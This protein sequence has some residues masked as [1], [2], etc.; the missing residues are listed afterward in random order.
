[1]FQKLKLSAKISFI[2]GATLAL[3]LTI[4][5]SVSVSQ[6][7]SAIS[8]GADG[9]FEG[10]AT[11][12][13]IMVQNLIDETSSIAANLQ[14]YLQMSFLF[15]SVPSTIK[16]S[17]LLTSRIYDVD[18]LSINYEVES[19]I[20][21]TAWAAVGNNEDI[22]AIN[23]LFEPYAFDPA[24]KDYSISVDKSCVE[25]KNGVSGG[26]YMDYANSDYY[27]FAK[28][29]K[30]PYITNPR[31]IDGNMISSIAYP[32]LFK[33][34]VV[35]VITVDIVTS[36]FKK[37]KSVDEEYSTLYVNILNEN[38]EIVFESGSTDMV[39][40][41]MSE[42]L[43]PHHFDELN[44]LA[45]QGEFFKMQSKGEQGLE[46]RYFYPINAPGQTW[47]AQ[48]YVLESDLNSS[49]VKISIL[50]IGLSVLA[51][52][53]IITLITILLRKMLKPI[54]TMVLAA[55]NIENG[56][57]DVSIK[58]NSQDEIGVLSKS[59][60]NM[61]LNLREIIFDINY[62]MTE[63]A[64]GNFT[65]SSNIEDKYV[66]E[67]R[68]IF[69]AM[70]HIKNNLCSALLKIN[71]S[72]DLVNIGSDQI[73]S[74]AQAL[75]HASAEQSCSIDDLSMTI[76]EMSDLIN[77]NVKITN[78]A[79]NVTAQSG[80]QVYESNSQMKAMVVAMNNINDKSNQIS[81]IIKTIE[82]LAFQTNIL[83]LNASIEAARA[84]EAG[85]GFAVVAHEVGN[86]AK[87]SSDAAKTTETLIQDTVTA[88]KKG[89]EI[90]DNTANSLLSVVSGSTE[91]S[92]LITEIADVSKE[93]LELI[94]NVTISVE[95]IS[96][97]V[98]TNSATA[99]ES[100][101]SSEELLG[102]SQLLKDLVSKFKLDISSAHL[103]VDEISLSQ[104]AN[105]DNASYINADQPLITSEYDKYDDNINNN[106]S[107]FYPDDD[108]TIINDNID[109]DN[110]V[111]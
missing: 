57:L 26:T 25:S 41:N 54:D 37:L 66:G 2:S 71:S 23:V 105:Y 58:I 63:M 73:S 35:G 94:N 40:V 55:Q 50:M 1:M 49:V 56:N 59:F 12:N 102:Q 74:G 78:N 31:S 68:E 89:T 48:S 110:D 3:I 103:Y 96:D 67:Y 84:G 85:R 64:K 100:A 75:S 87:K 107:E 30:E 61:S 14:D 99:E 45:E 86:L 47:W 5:I 83:A 38:K 39:G 10:I 93:Q 104:T 16:T 72:S 28:S 111:M 6:A 81:K 11:Q 21:N 101:A 92:R 53:T 19:Y 91:V 98:Q 42:F 80:S 34:E 24:I 33:N 29:S 79:I 43:K 20:L 82:D 32:I 69:L 18:L 46:E 97:I 36:N 106:I 77:K 7:R 44:Q 8:V 62:M 4:L 90:A 27:R 52:L 70:V 22:S 9:D 109:F 17:D 65:V 13:G 60:S 51:L 15:K 108:L 76:F 88:V 95:Q